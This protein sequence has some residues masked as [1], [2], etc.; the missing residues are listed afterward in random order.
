LSKG[1]SL[2]GLRL[3]FG[4][5]QPSLLSGLFKIKDSYNVDAIACLV[6]AAAMRDQAYK[7]ACAAKVKA[8]RQTLA[9]ALKQLGFQV[10]EHVQ[11]NFLLVTVPSHGN[12]GAL[13]QGL[14]DR[15]ILVRYFSHSGLENKLRITVGT[16][17]QN[18]LLIEALSSLL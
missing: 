17:E 14:K 13:Y 16:D 11:T 10:P 7:D 6:G 15:G 1:Y 5:A 4:L 12:A 18:D 2:A 8:S 3:G 9:I